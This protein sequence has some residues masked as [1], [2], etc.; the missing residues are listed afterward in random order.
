MKTMLKYLLILGIGSFITATAA[1]GQLAP[2]TVFF[3]ENGNGS[4]DSTQI[5][6]GNL[7][8]ST[9]IPDPISG[10][11]TLSYSVPGPVTGGDVLITEFEG[12]PVSDLL[13]FVQ[14]NGRF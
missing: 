11:V 10:I 3:D 1:R 8:P 14:A 2:V 4:S 5:P 12:A 13:R 9:T 7:N 6:F